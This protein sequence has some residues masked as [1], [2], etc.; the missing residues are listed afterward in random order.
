[1]CLGVIAASITRG[2]FNGTIS[3]ANAPLT[4]S[5]ID[6]IESIAGTDAKAAQQVQNIGYWINGYFTSSV[7]T[8]GVTEYQFNYT[9]IYAKNNSI[10][11]VNGTHSLI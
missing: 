10:R 9:L 5:Q 1:M 8:N 2:L 6:F 3:A 7:N 11:K 4:T